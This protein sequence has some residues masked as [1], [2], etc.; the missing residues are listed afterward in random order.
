MRYELGISIQNGD[1]VWLLGPFPCGSHPDIKIAR[2][3]I[4]HNIG[5]DEMILADSGYRD[6]G[7]YFDTP[8]GLN[9][10][11]QY[12]RSI[13]R[14]R[15]EIFNSR[16]KRFKILSTTYRGEISKHYLYFYTV[17]IMCQI[18]ISTGKKLFQIN[19][20]DNKYP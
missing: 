2:M 14:S 20:D 1:L 13:A 10:K 4:V 12:M 16:V 9:N 7:E 6:K 3:S 17:A 15:H 19:Y 11:G 5:V 8:T 18:E